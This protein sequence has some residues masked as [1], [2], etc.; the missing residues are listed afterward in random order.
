MRD[1][2]V[3][4]NR[5]HIGFYFF[6]EMVSKS[7]RMNETYS[8]TRVRFSITAASTRNQHEQQRHFL[9]PS[10]NNKPDSAVPDKTYN[11][12]YDH[13]KPKTLSG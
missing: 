1:N 6:S 3:E 9:G 7:I 10:I 12:K 5:Y 4:S 11:C 8:V 2:K 13:E